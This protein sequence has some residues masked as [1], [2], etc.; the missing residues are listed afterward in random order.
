V[1]DRLVGRLFRYFSPREATRGPHGLFRYPAKYLPQIAR[2]LLEECVAP[3][4]RILDPFAGSGTTLTEAAL[5]G[6][7]SVGLDLNPL[8]VLLSNAK[9]AGADPEAIRAAGRRVLARA[10]KGRAAPIPEF[11]NR[12][13]WFPRAAQIPLARLR[14]AI[15]GEDGAATTG[16]LLAVFLSIVKEASNAST[17]H[18][19]LTRSREPDPLT[20]DAVLDRFGKQVERAAGR[21]AEY[22]PLAPASCLFGDARRLPFCDG[23][24]DAIVSHPPY[25][26]SF[27]FVRVFKVYLWWLDPERDTV[28]LDRRMVGN[29]RRCT[30]EPPRL[31][32]PEIDDLSRRV[33]ERNARD[34][35]AVAHFYRD[36]AD[37]LAECRRVLVPGGRMAVY[38]GDSQARWISIDAPGNLTRLAERAGFETELR[39]PR[40]VPKKASSSI[41]NIDVEEILL[42]RAGP[43]RLRQ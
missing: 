10:A 26:I 35:L 15:R 4:A 13:Y 23:S 36:M 21:Y 29:Q 5:M 30:G 6:V 17:Y 25:S 34:G 3:G 33:W 28:A 40:V 41:R 27:D 19:K 14:R 8:A 16:I 24:F 42:F 1:R 37:H 31:G 11:P 9:S 22:A 39:L 20:G 2:A 18:Y 7:R 32:L 43:D 12:D 38:I